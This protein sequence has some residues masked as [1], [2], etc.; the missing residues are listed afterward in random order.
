[1]NKGVNSGRRCI[2]PGFVARHL[3]TPG[4]RAPRASPGGRF[5]AQTWH[6]HSFPGPYYVKGLFDVPPLPSILVH[7]H[8]VLM[9]GWVVLFSI[10]AWFISSKRIGLH[11]RVGYHGDGSADELV[12]WPARAD[13][14]RSLD[15]LCGVA[16]QLRLTI[17]ASSIENGA[18]HGPNAC[19]SSACHG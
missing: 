3:H 1:M 17:G 9:T 14:N 10:Q 19:R 18:A 5:D 2:P 6:L 8:G 16:R 7:V 11:Q 13:D 12:R 4:M 15:D